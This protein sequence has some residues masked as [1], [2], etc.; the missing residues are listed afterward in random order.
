MAKKTLQSFSMNSVL[1]PLLIVIA[2]ALFTWWLNQ[3][4][5]DVRYTL[6]EKV[7]VSFGGPLNE[8]VQQ[9]EVTNLSKKTVDRIRVKIPQPIIA[10][11]LIKNSQADVEEV[12]NGKEIF[13]LIYPTLPPEGSFR[14]VLKTPGAGLSRGSLEV[15]HGKGPAAYGFA[16][17][18]I[19]TKISSIA[20]IAFMLLYTVLLVRGINDSPV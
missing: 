19:T 10:H 5:Y 4:R 15:V 17:T 20:T 9:L 13:E 12:F 16:A 3:E 2:G 14:I 6:S 11:E 7:P 1:I 18:S 8:A